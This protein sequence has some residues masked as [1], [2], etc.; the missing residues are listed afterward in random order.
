MTGQNI[1]LEIQNLRLAVVIQQFEACDGSG[2]LTAALVRHHQEKSD[3]A[4]L[5][6]LLGLKGEEGKEE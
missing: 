6:H 3:K 4:E 2:V 5:Y 1:S